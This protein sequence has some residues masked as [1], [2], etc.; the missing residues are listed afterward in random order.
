MASLQER[1]YNIRTE[2]EQYKT[3]TEDVL[4]KFVTHAYDYKS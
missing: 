1:L 2:M 3:E 4:K